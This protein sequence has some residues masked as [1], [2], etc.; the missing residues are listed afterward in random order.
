MT[1]FGKKR[2]DVFENQVG[3]FEH[4]LVYLEHGWCIWTM[5]GV[6]GNP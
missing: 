4:C 3:V 6:F 5:F 2:T 1:V